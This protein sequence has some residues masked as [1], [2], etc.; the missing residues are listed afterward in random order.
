MAIAF[1]FVWMG[2]GIIGITLAQWPFLVAFVLIGAAGYA[3]AL[4]GGTPFR[5]GPVYIASRL[6]RDNLLFPTQVAILPSR[7]IRYKARLIGHN[8]ES[9]SIAQI[10]SVKITTSLLWSDVA[11]E[12]SGGQNQIVC[13]GH[14]NAD[15]ALMKAEIETYQH[16]YFT[17]LPRGPVP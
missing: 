8:E 13:H 9:I 10:A 16:A 12:S 11:I 6:A 3:L 14:T 1:L 15:A 2:I 7:V 17:A 5:D 4:R